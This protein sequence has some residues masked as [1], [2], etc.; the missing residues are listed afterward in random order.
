MMHVV[1]K[2]LQIFQ[3]LHEFPPN[4]R[5]ACLA[6]QKQNLPDVLPSTRN[7]Q[8]SP[9]NHHR[10]ARRM[11]QTTLTVLWLYMPTCHLGDSECSAS[12][13]LTPYLTNAPITPP[14][15][16]SR[17]PRPPSLPVKSVDPYPR[18]RQLLYSYPLPHLTSL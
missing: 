6:Y 1:R 10:G 13:W 9:S 14:P 5:P 8:N 18:R 3:R 2:L 11:L 15:P 4:S 16:P 7:M 17:L 12:K